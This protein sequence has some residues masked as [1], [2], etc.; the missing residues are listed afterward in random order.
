MPE[1]LPRDTI[2][3]E[4]DTLLPAVLDMLPDVRDTDDDRLA[5]F[6]PA[7]LLTCLMPDVFLDIPEDE[8]LDTPDEVLLETDVPVAFLEMVEFLEIDD[9]LEP[10]E[11]VEFLEP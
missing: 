6:L 5:V 10:Y 3:E 8:L 1:E 4:R 2:P 7:V 9:V 11:P